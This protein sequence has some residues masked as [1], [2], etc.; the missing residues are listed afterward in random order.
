[1]KKFFIT[2]LALTFITSCASKKKDNS[3]NPFNALT[4]KET[5][6][7]GKTPQSQVLHTF[8]APN[9]V[10]MDSSGQDVWAYQKE[11][12]E[13]NGSDA[14]AGIGAYIGTA[15]GAVMPDISGGVSNEKKTSKG[16]TVTMWFNKKKILQR[17][18]MTS[19]HF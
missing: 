12:S 1:M 13:W 4:L 14:S 7:K 2:M 17:Y 10:S 8:G 15:F 18:E 3:K 19:T 6:I 11:S 5:L 16:M 9:I